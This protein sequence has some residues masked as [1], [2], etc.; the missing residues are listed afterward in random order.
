MNQYGLFNSDDEDD[1]KYS[2]DEEEP[3]ENYYSDS[4]SLWIFTYY[5][6]NDTPEQDE[7]ISRHD[8]KI[9]YKELL[10]KETGITSSLMNLLLP[11][12]QSM[13]TVWVIRFGHNWWCNTT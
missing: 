12:Q 13:G 2:P 10:V 1:M 8:V 3:E 5:L 4:F 9:A 11:N 6:W 7:E